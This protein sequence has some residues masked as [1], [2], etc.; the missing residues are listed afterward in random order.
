MKYIPSTTDSIALTSVSIITLGLFIAGLFDVL[1]YFIIKAILILGYA[2]LLVLAIMY[3][4][5]NQVK[6]NHLEEFPQDD[7][8]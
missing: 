1:D 8:N 5:K 2:I 4:L 7:L 3:G 6:K